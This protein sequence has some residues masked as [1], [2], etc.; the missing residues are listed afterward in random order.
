MI[1]LQAV[2]D[3]VR[4]S[5]VSSTADLVAAVLLVAHTGKQ[6]QIV[7][8]SGHWHVVV[9]TICSGGGERVAG[10]AAASAHAEMMTVH[11]RR[12]LKTRNITTVRAY[13]RDRVVGGGQ[14][15]VLRILRVA[16]QHSRASGALQFAQIRL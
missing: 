2:E 11:R 5:G 15:V 7:E 12:W 14:A 16:G 10:S 4:S 9:L 13:K 3:L 6:V 8:A 1:V